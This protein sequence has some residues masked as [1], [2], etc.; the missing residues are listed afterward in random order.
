[1]I[2]LGLYLEARGQFTAA[3]LHYRRGLAIY[4]RSL[5]SEHPNIAS[6]LDNFALLLKE[7]NR[8]GEAEPLMR[9]AA[10]DEHRLGRNTSKSPSPSTTWRRCSRTP[11]GWARPSP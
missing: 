1:M 4:E 8:L 11:T 3:E 5:G 6:C 2:Q 7:T 9:R 10:I